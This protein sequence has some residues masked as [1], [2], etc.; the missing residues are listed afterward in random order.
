MDVSHMEYSKKGYNAVAGD[1][2]EKNDNNSQVEELE[3][4]LYG[5]LPEAT[6]IRGIPTPTRT[7]S[8]Y[9]QR[10]SVQEEQD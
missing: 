2:R 10:P 8:S 4:P 7:L 6:A 5:H 3:I 9:E 1:D